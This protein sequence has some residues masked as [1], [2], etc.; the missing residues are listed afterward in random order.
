MLLIGRLAAGQARSYFDQAEGQVDAVQSIGDGIRTGTA[1]FQGLKWR[2][3]SACTD[4][5]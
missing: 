2:L 3:G 4:L 1:A 5:S